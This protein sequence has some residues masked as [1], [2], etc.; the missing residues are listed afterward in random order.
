[1]NDIFNKN[2]DIP[3]IINNLQNPE[4]TI[5]AHIIQKQYLRL[6][7]KYALSK[8]RKHTL[9]GCMEF[10]LLY[11]RKSKQEVLNLPYNL[12]TYIVSKKPRLRK[13]KCRNVFSK[14]HLDNNNN[15]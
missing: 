5:T 12:P 14:R 1:M 4:R 8:S 15:F 6:L 11:L 2:H 3:I 13:K 9:A 7:H 10:F